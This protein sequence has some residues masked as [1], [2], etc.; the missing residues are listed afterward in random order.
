MDEAQAEPVD[1]VVEEQRRALHDQA[2][3]RVVPG[4]KGR[5]PENVLG[6]F[7]LL[8]IA[9][10]RGGGVDERHHGP[11]AVRPVGAHRRERHQH[12]LGVGKGR[13]AKA[14]VEVAAR[15]GR[16]RRRV[17][18]GDGAHGRKRAAMAE[19]DRYFIQ[20]SEDRRSA[21]R[22]PGL[23]RQ[24]GSTELERSQAD[25]RKSAAR[26]Q[27]VG[28]HGVARGHVAK[29][30]R[31]PV[32]RGSATP[33]SVRARSRDRRRTRPRGW[34]FQRRT[35]RCATSPPGFGAGRGAVAI[36]PDAR[37]AHAR[38]RARARSVRARAARP[39]I[40]PTTPC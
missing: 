27:R 13:V 35:S 4:G 36:E 29:H 23:A 34:L 10:P 28:V 21:S 24:A 19:A 1:G 33:R 15:K 16:R 25:S 40:A 7:E 3:L 20:S 37:V 6:R 17:A 11:V 18:A 14:K 5:R 39:P 22:L 30:R 31:R 8:Q 2:H 38:G 9:G 26:R 12:G 32:A